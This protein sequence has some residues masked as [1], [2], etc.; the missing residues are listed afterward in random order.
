MSDFGTFEKTVQCALKINSCLKSSIRG[1]EEA[2]MKYHQSCAFRS[3]L[4]LPFCFI[5]L[6]VKKDTKIK[7][8]K[9][10]DLYFFYRILD[11]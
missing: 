2:D 10:I 3:T 9:L 6:E 8:Q 1:R 11:F 4:K 7:F 5:T